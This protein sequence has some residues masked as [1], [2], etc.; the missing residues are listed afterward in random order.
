[1]IRPSAALVFVLVLLIGGT[2][3][4]ADYYVDAVNGND[5]N[6]GLSPAVAFETI[7]HAVEMVQASGEEPATIYV[8]TGIYSE[9]T[10][11]EK[12]PIEVPG[13]VLIV[14]AGRDSVVLDG[15][16]E[17]S[18]LIS[19]GSEYPARAANMTFTNGSPFALIANYSGKVISNCL[20]INN[21]L[22]VIAD[23]PDYLISDCTF[24]NSMR[25]EEGG[26]V[27][28]GNSGAIRS[29]VFIGHTGG[30]GALGIGGDV[31]PTIQDCI[32]SNNHATISGG[33]LSVGNG[34]AMSFRNCLFYENSSPMGGVIYCTN[35]EPMTFEN[36]TFADNSGENG[37]VIHANDTQVNITNSIL[38]G[39]G[40]NAIFQEVGLVSVSYSCVEDGREGEG[41]I[42]EDPRFTIGP[43]GKCYLSCMAA[44]QTMDSPCVDSGLGSSSEFGL[45]V[46]TT[47][48]DALLDS[49]VV[50]M[51]YH[52]VPRRDVLEIFV[53][54]V[55]GSDY[56]SGV[57]PTE[58]FR[59]ISHALEAAEEVEESETIRITLAP[60]IYSSTTNNER[61]PL[62][63]PEIDAA[64]E[65]IGESRDNTLIRMEPSDEADHALSISKQ[66]SISVSR[67]SITGNTYEGSGS[68]HGLWAENS[69]LFLSGCRFSD[70]VFGDAGSAFYAD[71]CGDILIENCEFISNTCW[72]SVGGAGICCERANSLIIRNSYF[73][74]N[75]A[76][77]TGG[78]IYCYGSDL[79]QIENSLMISSAGLFGASA[80][81]A[82][83]N[84]E[85]IICGVTIADIETGNLAI[86]VGG[87]DTL[88]LNSLF[89]STGQAAAGE[90]YQ[91]L[92][93]CVEGGHEGEGNI[94][95]DP[96]FAEG[97]FGDYY[98]SS[99]EAG[100]DADSPCIDAGWGNVDLLELSDMTTRTDNLP[101]EGRCD[102]GYHYPLPQIALG[103]FTSAFEYAPGDPLEAGILLEN[104]GPA[105]YA[106]IYLAF[107]L[108]DGFVFSCVGDG[109][110]AGIY[111][112]HRGSYLPERYAFGPELV[113]QI[114]IPDGLPDGDYLFIAAVACEGHKEFI[115]IAEA[116]FSVE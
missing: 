66:D 49:G 94:D 90:N 58:A 60:G 27:H 68:G 100:Q 95:A 79:L 107:V 55:E 2:S 45:D 65:L 16:K 54:A 74:E 17:G 72:F 116:L 80:I 101:D 73:A 46:L 6:S 11:G 37:S 29:C 44:G 21:N 38:W 109:W 35:C 114:Q 63:F 23:G 92:Y 4:A 83:G 85:V 32:F 105:F 22:C 62:E 53:D 36:C 59:T 82:P 3:V 86:D 48:T 96:F 7:A 26:A 57:S 67:L 98:L 43:L 52:Y 115:R 15:G 41:N 30:G 31:A 69:N 14:G 75:V 28:L 25:I 97:P 104:P 19:L 20:F 33:V 39:N 50:D 24:D 10:N 34:P 76:S 42:S 77:N 88:I 64:F 13:Y 5:R 47:R 113:A 108:P 84:D 9:E 99:I 103:C 102:I 18:V 70:C 91:I 89:W 51:G 1:M 110:S 111:P 112:W 87:S 78:A 8:A 56:R 61:F 93:S 81:Y 40:E 106:D 71:D 12:F